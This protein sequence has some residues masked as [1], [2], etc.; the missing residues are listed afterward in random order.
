[1]VGLSSLLLGSL[2]RQRTC[3]VTSSIPAP[4]ANP[5]NVALTIMYCCATGLFSLKPIANYPKIVNRN[6]KLRF[7]T[8]VSKAFK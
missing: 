1:M 7:E 3:G 4:G 2:L 6:F 5:K 8:S